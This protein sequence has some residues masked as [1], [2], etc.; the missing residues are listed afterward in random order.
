MLSICMSG[1]R[2]VRPSLYCN[3]V[4]L[5]LAAMVAAGPVRAEDRKVLGVGRHFNNDAIGDGEDRWRTGSYVVSVVRGERWG[6][7]APE[8]FGD[9]LE[10]RLRLETITAENSEN[11]AAGDRPYAGLLS[12]GVHG[13]A[14]PG[15]YDLSIGADLVSLGPANQIGA[16]HQGFHDL[17]GLPTPDT[18][19]QIG[20][21]IHPMVSGELSRTF[22]VAD[23][24]RLRPYVAA[25]AGFET[26]FRVGGDMQFGS[27]L[28]SDLMLRDVVTG[29]F[30]PGT[31]A[32]DLPGPT[33]T[34]GADV[35]RVF[36]SALLPDELGLAPT[37]TRLRL[38]TGV[39]V[40]GRDAALFYGVT[41]LSE[42]FEAQD[43]PQVVG[44]LQLDIFF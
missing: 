42:E 41:W 16:L 9:L 19:A 8:A 6:G 28:D 38:R 22:Q 32:D 34:L 12:F 27:G 18:S 11:P 37:D 4:F 30:Y 33:F 2:R 36:G 39:Q 26:L 17:I 10:W 3:L 13:H 7:R 35:A 29:F 44:S 14:A 21:S 24:I 40:Q 20:D 31:R 15:A 23:G 1:C 5:I 43:E 25:S